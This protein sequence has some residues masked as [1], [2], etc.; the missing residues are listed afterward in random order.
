MIICQ[1]S[2]CI[3]TSKIYK[4]FKDIS[5]RYRLI[6]IKE[7]FKYII[8][9][10]NCLKLSHMKY[11]SIYY[12]FLHVKDQN[13]NQYYVETLP[14]PRRMVLQIF[15]SKIC[16]NAIEKKVLRDRKLELINDIILM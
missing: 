7:N 13:K 1:K 10:L 12:S 14:Y 5:D 9:Y 2:L 8:V 16:C 6:L 11:I 3:K 15:A 4:S